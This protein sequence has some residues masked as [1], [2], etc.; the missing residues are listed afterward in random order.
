MS[1]SVL[2]HLV[3]EGDEG[4][5]EPVEVVVGSPL[6]VDVEPSLLDALLWWYGAD[7][8][9]SRASPETSYPRRRRRAMTSS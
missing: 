1:P 6:T 4:F 3:I 7:Q 2:G 8:S 9:R 5:A